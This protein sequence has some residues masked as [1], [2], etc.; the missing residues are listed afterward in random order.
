MSIGGFKIRNK[1]E[2]HFLT[3]TVVEWIDV[4]TRKEYRDVLLD[5]IRFCQQNKN[6]LLHCWC[7]MSNHLHLIG[8]SK[9]G[10]LSEII[11]DL[12][13]YTSRQII[14]AIDKNE[15]E[16]RKGWLLSQFKRAGI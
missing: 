11:R 7:L 12:K 13:K 8:S 3:F 16:S 14:E 2:T 15:R 6:L 4:F 9:E 10:K 5:S 1:T